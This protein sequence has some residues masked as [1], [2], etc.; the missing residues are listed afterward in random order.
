MSGPWEEYQT[1]TAKPK[2]PAAKPAGPWDDYAAAPT[3]KVAAVKELPQVT[4]LDRTRAAAAGVNRGLFNDLLGLPVD[5][6]ANLVDL[7]KIAVGGG[8][9]GIKSAI[10][11]K[12]EVPPEWS[13]PSDRSKIVGSSEWLNRKTNDIG[14]GAAVNNPAPQ[15][16]ASRILHTGGRFAGASVVPSSR[17]PLSASSQLT[18]AGMGAASGLISGGVNEFAPE[19]AGLAGMAPSLGVHMGANGIKLAARGGEAGRQAMNQRMQDLKAGGVDSPSVGLATGRPTIM[20]LENLLAQTP[21]SGGL[22]GKAG[23]ANIAGMKAKTDSVRDAISSEYGP[24][25]AGQAVQGDIKGAFRDRTKATAGRLADKVADVVGRESIV[26]VNASMAKARQLSTPTKGAEATSGAL[27]QPRISR[28][29]DNLETDVFGPRLDPQRLNIGNPTRN[30]A[31]S[32]LPQLRDAG[33]LMNSQAGAPR[34]VAN[35]SIWNEPIIPRDQL[36]QRGNAP[37]APGRPGDSLMNNQK[38]QGIPFGAL[39]S[40]RTSI[41]EETQSNAIMGTP[42]QAQFKQLYGAM[43]QDMRQAASSAD[44]ARAGVDVGPL[45]PSQQPAGVALTR[46]NKHFST[47]MNRA[48]ELNGIANRSTPEGAYGAVEQSLRSGPTTW[49]RTRSAVTPATRQKVAATMIDE[50]GTAT[51]GQQTAAGDAWSARTFLTNY[52]KLYQNGGGKALFTRLP[53]GQAHAENLASIA[54]A[55]DMV[56]SASKVWANPSGTAPALTARGTLYTLTAGAFIQ[57]MLAASTAGGLVGA[58][59][60]SQRLLLNPKFVSWLA[61]SPNVPPAQARAHAQRLMGIATMSRDP[62]F[63]KDASDYLD[64]VEQGQQQ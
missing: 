41:G 34:T 43:S 55:A 4:G 12:M 3:S 13:E 29:A 15:D 37:S 49:E 54:K 27:I 56:G 64:L 42:E 50:M 1:T 60:I 40:L 19:W 9:T 38:P 62:Q 18:N 11:G 51:P 17:I 36:P 39:K 21:F 33:G 25:V 20:G 59:Q 48:D 22:Y 8:Y 31:I 23:Q 45:T 61:K 44:R 24:V 26:P 5:T 30:S 35:P 32:S 58:R 52:N 14:M 47:A 46:A 6:A 57:P 53:G 63:K 10:T 16:A 2:P 28:I 7:A